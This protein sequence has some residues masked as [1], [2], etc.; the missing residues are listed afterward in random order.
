M[1]GPEADPTAAPP[2][3]LDDDDAKFVERLKR[4]GFGPLKNDGGAPNEAPAAVPATAPVATG[5]GQTVP[6]NQS[7]DAMSEVVTNIT[8]AIAK[9]AVA[10]ATEG[11]AA[12][13]ARHPVGAVEVPKKKG[14]WG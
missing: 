5:G 9:G 3:P 1:S 13:T 2:P 10:A 8:Q 11:I 6:A 12:A 7:A 14:F 4:L